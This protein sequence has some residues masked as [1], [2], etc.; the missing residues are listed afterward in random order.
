MI[1]AVIVLLLGVSVVSSMPS[2]AT[3]DDIIVNKVLVAIVYWNTNAGSDDAYILADE[4]HGAVMS[5]KTH[6]YLHDLIGAN[7]RTG[8]TASGYTLNTKSD[9]ALKFDVTDGEF[10]DED[11]EV[12]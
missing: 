10:Y 5:G 3:F 2:H 11:L 4:R 1:F 7:Y 6:E 9:A 8:L 12:E